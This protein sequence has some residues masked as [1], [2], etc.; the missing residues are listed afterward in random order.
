MRLLILITIFT[1]LTACSLF[2]PVNN[3]SNT[4]VLNKLP[5]QLPSYS[6]AKTTI[7][8]AAPD[9]LPVFNTTQM[10][11]TTKPFYV[12]YF[13]K[14]AWAETPAQMLSALIVQTLQNTH[15]YR[16]VITLPSAGYYNYILNTQITELQQ[17]FTHRTP[18]VTFS[19]RAQLVRAS[20]NRVIASKQF[21]VH[22][23]MR[24]INPY[25]GVIAANQAVAKVLRQLAVFCNEN[26]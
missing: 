20:T 19:L 18:F 4:Y 25:S 8:V 1:T 21:T 26:T 12:T 22:Q 11:Y 23:P 17:D 2:S 10:A 13:S 6:R 7:L 14:N 16:A 9:S 5:C 24:K 15:G 3:T